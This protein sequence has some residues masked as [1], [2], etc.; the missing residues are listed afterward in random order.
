M[1][2]EKITWTEYQEAVSNRVIILPTGSMEQHGYH[3][4][5]NVDVVIPTSL[6]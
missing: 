4:P 2:A 6:A 5:L 3:L 1:Q